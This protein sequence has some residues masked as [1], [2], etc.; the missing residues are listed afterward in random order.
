M[1]NLEQLLKKHKV[2]TN[3][4]AQAIVD[5]LNTTGSVNIYKI[6]TIEKVPA[7]KGVININGNQPKY[8]YRGKIKWS[9]RF[10]EMI[11]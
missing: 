8:K 4:F 3:D 5:D 2:K 1:T 6:L 9:L 7:R 10:K 11:N